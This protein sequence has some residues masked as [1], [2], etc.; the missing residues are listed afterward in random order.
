MSEFN[1]VVARWSSRYVEPESPSEW[2]KC[3]QCNYRPKV[4]EF[5]NGRFAQC[6]CSNNYNIYGKK[7]FS[8]ESIMSVITRTGGSAAPYDRDALRKEWNDYVLRSESN[9]KD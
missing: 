4:W 7:S 6:A 2:E 1:K 9:A 8:S 5:D 3:K